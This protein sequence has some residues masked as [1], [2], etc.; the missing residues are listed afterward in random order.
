MQNVWVI[1]WGESGFYPEFFEDISMLNHVNAGW[2]KGKTWWSAWWVRFKWSMVRFVVFGRVEYH[3]AR[4]PMAVVPD[5][6][7]HFK[8]M[9][10]CFPQVYW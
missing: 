1:D 2:F 9:Q 10:P 6:S 3:P 7:I 5:R 4:T 8:L